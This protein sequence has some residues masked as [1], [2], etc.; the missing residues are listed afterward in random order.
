MRHK[1]HQSYERVVKKEYEDLN[2]QELHLLDDTIPDP[3]P[4]RHCALRGITQERKKAI[5]QLESGLSSVIPK[6]G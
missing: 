4:T 2:F 5:L 1:S 6:K 3:E